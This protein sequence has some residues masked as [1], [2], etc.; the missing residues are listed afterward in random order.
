MLRRLLTSWLRSRFHNWSRLQEVSSRF[1]ASLG[2]LQVFS[3]GTAKEPFVDGSI[4]GR[5]FSHQT[6]GGL[7]KSASR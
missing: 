7:D 5:V 2:V 4:I 3:E 1:F 6:E